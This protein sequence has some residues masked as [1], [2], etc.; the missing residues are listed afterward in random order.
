MGLGMGFIAL[1]MVA[2]TIFLSSCSPGF[3]TLPDSVVAVAEI[4]IVNKVSKENYLNGQK[5]CE[6]YVNNESPLSVEVGKWI[7]VPFDYATST[8]KVKIYAYTKKTFNPQLPSYIVVDG[9]PGQNTHMT[10]EI[11]DSGFNEIRFDQRGVGCS[12]PATWEEYSDQKLYSSLYTANDID[13]IRKAYGLT[14]VSIYGVSYGTVPA[15]IY[16]NRYEGNVR[17]LVIEGVLGKIENLS[18]RTYDVDKYNL[19]FN[20]LTDTQKDSFTKVLFGNDEKKQKVLR[21]FLEGA[22]YQDGG[23]RMVRDVVFKKLF[24]DTGEIDEAA[25]A[26]GYSLIF[27]E[28]S[29][30]TTPQQP[31]AVDENV[32]LRFYCKE[33]GGFSQDKFSLDFSRERGF[34]ER[35][36]SGKTRWSEDCK[37]VGIDRSMENNYDEKSYPTSVP[38]YYFQ[39]SHDGATIADGALSHW[40]YVPINKS[41]FLLSLR[42]GHNPA[43]SKLKSGDREIMTLHKELFAKSL[44]AQSIQVDFVNKLNLAISSTAEKNEKNLNFNTWKLFSDNKTSYIEIEKEF[45]G[46]RRLSQRK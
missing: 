34:F 14:I 10:N 37:M 30:Y 6:K 4:P 28:T 11:L 3:E 1:L 18:R 2:L 26:R 23:Y 39:G 38:V 45:N 25:F 40:K 9:G 41:Y 42:G 31:G 12:A 44:S 36:T 22:R 24:K 27:S 16:A 5:F 43:L 13:E 20:S 8:K 21:Y 32:L 7:D 46:L 15:T 17:S 19:I 35:A 29:E 33:L